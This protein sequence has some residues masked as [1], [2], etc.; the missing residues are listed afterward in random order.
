MPYERGSLFRLT[1]TKI[2]DLIN[3]SD[4][5]T[6]QFRQVAKCK[7]GTP[8]FKIDQFTDKSHAYLFFVSMIRK[9]SSFLSLTDL[10]NWLLNYFQSHKVCFIFLCKEHYIFVNKKMYHTLHMF[11][12][13]V[14]TSYWHTSHLLINSVVVFISNFRRI[15]MQI[16]EM[17]LSL[18]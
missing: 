12:A 1:R 14:N 10:L 6:L 16:H 18:L 4:D 15:S 11:L 13:P 9:F 7:L 2:K 3:I 17:L 5:L 8:I